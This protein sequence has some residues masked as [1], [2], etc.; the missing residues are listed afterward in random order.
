VLLYYRGRLPDFNSECFISVVGTRRLTDYGRKNAFSIG[1]DLAKSGAIVVSGMAIGIDG[2]SMAGALSAEG[3]TVAFLGCGINICYPEGHLT[4][5]KEIVK[6]GCILTEF[7]P[8]TK[9]DGRNFPIRNRL[10][11]GI[12]AATVVIEG[13]ERSGSMITARNA[14]NQ[15]KALYALPGNVDN[16]TSEVSNTLIKNGAKLITNAYDIIRDFEF[17]YTGKINPFKLEDKNSVKMFD[18]LSHY[19]IQCVTHSDKEFKS[20]RPKKHGIKEKTVRLETTR[21]DP[22]VSQPKNDISFAEAGFDKSTIKV[23]MK[24]PPN[25]AVSYSSLC[26]EE[27]DMKSVMRAIFQL[28]LGNFIEMLPGERVKRK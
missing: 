12:S 11:S 8:D 15:G 23:Y 2:V 1:Y 21:E 16:K 14:K 18:V 17:V 19:K 27:H 25:E 26:D 9:P 7:P 5:A 24:I 10:I 20:P 13:G 3:V 28:D 4:L 22:I 6:N